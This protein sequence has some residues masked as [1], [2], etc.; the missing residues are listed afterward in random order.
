M[1]KVQKVDRSFLYTLIVLVLFGFLTFYSAATGLAARDN[2]NFHSLITNQFIVGIV[3]GF[4][5]LWLFSHINNEFFKKW[6]IPIFIGSVILTLAVFVPELGETHR[7]STRWLNLGFVSFQ[8]S[9]L[10]KVSAIIFLASWFSFHKKRL[11]DNLFPVISVGTVLLISAIPLILQRDFDVIFIMAVPLIMMYLVA[12]ASFR[13]VAILILILG[14]IFGILFFT[15]PHINSRITG[16]FNPNEGGQTIN[17]QTQQSQIAIGSGGIFGKGYGK[18]TQKFGNLP[19]PT[20]DSIFAVLAE[21]L[22][23]LGA[24]FLILLYILFGAFGY[25]IASRSKTV[26]GSL[27]TFGI[28]TL[29]LTQSFINIA[30]MIGFLPI[31]GQ[32]LVFVSLGG[33][34]MAVTMAMMGII[35]HISRTAKN[36]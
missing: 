25:K 23:M 16:F 1:S 29:I 14:I 34:S 19:E 6:A 24:G 35:L 28:I 27:F 31:T 17:Y 8:P 18:S 7:G 9:E 2:I 15:V 20:S 30:S 33:T 21:E 3:I 12:K 36:S 13:S 22:G 5:L 26:F 4:F 10:L 11:K 32:P